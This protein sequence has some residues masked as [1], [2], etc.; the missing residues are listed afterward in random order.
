MW[1]PPRF[2][3]RTRRGAAGGPAAAPPVAPRRKGAF[4]RRSVSAGR[5]ERWQTLNGPPRGFVSVGTLEGGAV[6][7]PRGPP[8]M[9][10]MNTLLRGAALARWDGR[11]AMT[12]FEW[13]RNC[14]RR[15]A[16]GA[17]WVVCFLR[18]IPR[19]TFRVSVETFVEKHADSSEDSVV[20]QGAEPEMTAV[21]AFL[22]HSC[23]IYGVGKPW[24]RLALVP[25]FNAIADDPDYRPLIA[26]ADPAASQPA[27][28]DGS[29]GSE[30]RPP[31]AHVPSSPRPPTM[32][33]IRAAEAMADA[34][35]PEEDLDN[36]PI[37]VPPAVLRAGPPR[38]SNTASPQ[39]GREAWQRLNHGQ[40]W[41][42]RRNAMRRIDSR[43]Q[44]M[45][46]GPEPAVEAPPPASPPPASPVRGV[47]SP[48]TPLSPA[49]LV[50]S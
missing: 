15:V 3:L 38:V 5:S 41:E 8:S 25:R 20:V 11:L 19:H 37:L 14:G 39:I 17:S 29:T 43:Q 18:R 48:S 2:G 45:T 22:R 24:F 28:H 31:A 26:A 33:A 23:A 7:A 47:A 42:H 36:L 35:I 4:M 46:G 49:P 13:T 40:Q 27:G 12:E 1:T 32:D 30:N 34:N 50:R 44:W 21:L 9:L 16:P 10:W 6:N